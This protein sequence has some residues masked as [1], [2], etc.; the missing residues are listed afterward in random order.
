MTH[1][2]WFD[3][4]IAFILNERV[5][6]YDGYMMM[7]EVN[8]ARYFFPGCHIDV[9]KDYAGLDRVVILEIPE[10]AA[11]GPDAAASP[12]LDY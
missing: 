11:P 5:F 7:E 4:H 1:S 12:A 6:H 9:F 8:L 10:E 2:G 3:G